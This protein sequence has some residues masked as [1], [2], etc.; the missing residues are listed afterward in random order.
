MQGGRGNVL[1]LARLLD[2][3]ARFIEQFRDFANVVQVPVTDLHANP[4]HFA[5]TQV[6]A[7]TAE[8]ERKRK[9]DEHAAITKAA[10]KLSLQTVFIRGARKTCMINNTLYT[11][12]DT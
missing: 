7:N 6:Q 12:R 11:E 9:D 8:V 5:R 10:Q 2:G 4:F 3:T 1:A